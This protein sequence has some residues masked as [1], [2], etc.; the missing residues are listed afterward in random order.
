MQGNECLAPDDEVECHGGERGDVEY[1]DASLSDDDFPRWLAQHRKAAPAPEVG[2][3]D[4]TGAE[5]KALATIAGSKDAWPKAKWL[6]SRGVD[7]ATLDELGR[8]GWL[9]RWTKG[10]T[11]R[12][13]FTP[14]GAYTLKQTLV[15]EPK[16]SKEPPSPAGSPSRVVTCEA[17]SAAMELVPDKQC[18]LGHRLDPVQRRVGPQDWRLRWVRAREVPVKEAPRGNDTGPALRREPAGPKW[19]DKNRRDVVRPE[20]IHHR[21][22]LRPGKPR[23]EHPSAAVSF[24]LLTATL[25]HADPGDHGSEIEMD[26]GTA[27]QAAVG[28]AP[29]RA[30][31][32]YEPV[33]PT[34]GPAERAAL[35]EET[36]AAMQKARR[37]CS[38]A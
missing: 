32:D 34:D 26:T 17:M 27:V 3:R 12:W 7:E 9:V 20:A 14:W 10:R 1:D 35:R 11:T 16:W 22:I 33:A 29:A 28:C 36:E 25:G 30:P 31:T 18:T 38:S 6:A 15:E 23:K 4:L 13:T 8:K 5:N 37:K 21:G 2:R 19:R 24:D